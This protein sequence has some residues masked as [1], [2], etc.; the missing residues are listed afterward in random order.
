M[1]KE[2]NMKANVFVEKCQDA[3]FDEVR[4]MTQHL[5]EDKVDAIRA[6]F[7][8]IVDSKTK[9]VER[10]KQNEK[11]R[12]I[13][14]IKNE[15]GEYCVAVADL[16]LYAIETGLV[17]RYGSEKFKTRLHD[18]WLQANYDFDLLK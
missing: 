15:N 6:H 12:M 1:A 9:E 16:S 3:G 8:K 5:P 11:H 7:Q 18:E 2:F 13:G 4:A 14:V 17:K 10:Q